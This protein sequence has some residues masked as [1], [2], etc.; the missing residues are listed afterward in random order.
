MLE[1][2]V[3]MGDLKMAHKKKAHVKSKSCAGMPKEGAMAHGGKA[4]VAPM[5]KEKKAGRGK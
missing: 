1:N 4:M 5:A 2:P 3:T